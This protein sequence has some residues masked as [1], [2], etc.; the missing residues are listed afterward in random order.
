MNLR[1]SILFYFHKD[2]GGKL[3]NTKVVETLDEDV[4]PI[5]NTNASN[6]LR[7]QLPEVLD[8]IA[9]FHSLTKVK[10]I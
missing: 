6:S 9:D 3:P 4:S 2:I 7:E 10:V 8:F 5:F 1:N